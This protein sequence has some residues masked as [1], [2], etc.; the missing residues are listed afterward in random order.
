[1][2]GNDKGAKQNKTIK[3]QNKTIKAQNMETKNEHKK[4]KKKRKK[5]IKNKNITLTFLEGLVNIK[6]SCL[7]LWRAREHWDF[8]TNKIK[9]LV[10]S[11]DWWAK[12]HDFYEFS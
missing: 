5:Q 8:E 6:T 3:A 1:M 2:K 7:L 10:F 11:K 4:N 9:K 12:K